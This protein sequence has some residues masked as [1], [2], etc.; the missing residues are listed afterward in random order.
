MAFRYADLCGDVCRGGVRTFHVQPGDHLNGS[1]SMAGRNRERARQP[2]TCPCAGAIAAD[3]RR[4][5]RL[6]VVAFT[7]SVGVNTRW[8]GAAG[9]RD[10]SLQRR[11]RLVRWLCPRQHL[12][13]Q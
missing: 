9:T 12:H 6:L 11:R 7:R 2:N 10:C 5:D 8:T 4:T 1:P 13:H 3:G